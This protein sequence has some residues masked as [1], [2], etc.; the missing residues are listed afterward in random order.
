MLLVDLD[1]LRADPVR[2]RDRMAMV[3]ALARRGDVVVLAGQEGAVLEGDPVE[4]EPESVELRQEPVEL[5]PV[6]ALQPVALQPAGS[7]LNC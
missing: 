6:L 2:W 5:A 7:G 3:V 4:L 1:N